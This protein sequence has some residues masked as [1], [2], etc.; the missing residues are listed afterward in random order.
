[1]KNDTTDK[2]LSRDASGARK[3]NEPCPI[4]WKEP[5]RGNTPES[6]D[7]GSIVD[8]MAHDPEWERALL[9]ARAIIGSRDPFD[10][11][12]RACRIIDD[13]DTY[14]KFTR[15]QV[16]EL[17]NGDDLDALTAAVIEA[18]KAAG[19]LPK[20]RRRTGHK[21]RETEV[22]A[23]SGRTGRLSD[24]TLRDIT[25]TIVN[26]DPNAARLVMLLADEIQRLSDG[27]NWR[28]DIDGLCN[29]VSD[30]AFRFSIEHSDCARVLV[31]ETRSEISSKAD[32]TK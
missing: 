4:Y 10:T 15:D 28:T 22:A 13:N 11:K 14:S 20:P 18:E 5:K 2:T 17:Y 26:G 23:V 9:E 6:V 12:N 16:D 25:A 3:I 7:F 29:I 24:Q 31:E 8:H 32:D 21:E 27:Y 19:K 30:E 1:M